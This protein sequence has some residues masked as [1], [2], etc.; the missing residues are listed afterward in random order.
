MKH[1]YV[2]VPLLGI[3][4]QLDLKHAVKK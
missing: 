3:S 4:F 1:A 2:T